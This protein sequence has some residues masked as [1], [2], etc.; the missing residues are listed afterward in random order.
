MGIQTF[1]FKKMHL[2]IF[3]AKWRTF[4]LGLN[5]LNSEN[6]TQRQLIFNRSIWQ[7]P[8]CT[9]PISHTTQLRTEMCTFLFWVVYYG[10]WDRCIVGFSDCSFI[11]SFAR[12]EKWNLHVSRQDGGRMQ[13]KPGIMWVTCPFTACSYFPHLFR[14]IKTLAH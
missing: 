11:N 4:C 12:Q 14:I 1:S 13:Q 9:C 7:I 3:S 2:K 8:Q 10:I 6:N 5:V